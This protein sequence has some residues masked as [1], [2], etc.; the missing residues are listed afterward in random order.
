LGAGGNI[1]AVGGASGGV[2]TNVVQVYDPASNSWAAL[3]F[4]LP[5]PKAPATC[6]R[7]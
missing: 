1:Y 7:P 2:T 4:S 3:G 5:Y 6:K